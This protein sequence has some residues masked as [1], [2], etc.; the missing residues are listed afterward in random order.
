[1]KLYP[2]FIFSF[3]LFMISTT[4]VLAHDGHAHPINFNEL[5][6]LPNFDATANPP[7]NVSAYSV[8]SPKKSKIPHPHPK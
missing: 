4:Q 1:M 2:S 3:L 6:Y 5:T 8:A 7:L